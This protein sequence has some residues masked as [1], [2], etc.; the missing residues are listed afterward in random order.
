MEKSFKEEV[1]KLDNTSRAGQLARE[2][3]AERHRLKKELD[4]VVE[5]PQK[6]GEIQQVIQQ[7]KPALNY[8]DSIKSSIMDKMQERLKMKNKTMRL[9]T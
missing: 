4:E 6:T 2:L 1:G 3:N 8:N 5:P 7:E 9:P